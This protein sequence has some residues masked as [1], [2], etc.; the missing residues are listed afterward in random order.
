[1]SREP[2]FPMM[3]LEHRSPLYEILQ[4]KIKNYIIQNSLKPG[5]RLPPE[6]ELAQQLGVSRNSVREAVKALEMLD[7]VETRSGAG[8]FV[9]EFSFDALLDNFGYGIMFNLTE[10]AD[11]LEVRFHVE[12]GMI[13]RAVE[14]VTP[15]QIKRLR[16]IVEQM[17][18]AAK[19]D[20]YSAKND[21]LFH[22]TLWE[23]VDNRVVG[24]ILDVFWGILYQ[25]RKQTPVP[26][27]GDLMQTYERHL[28]IVEALEKQDVKALQR[29]MVFHYGGIR[30]RLEGIYK[31]GSIDKG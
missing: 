9:G 22:Q 19:N 12:Y 14:A 3:P 16:D 18:V 24:K 6:T 27:P 10:L 29:S 4:Q 31:H 21:R 23:N 13:P 5:D 20:N 1:M 25:A 26:D 15:E 8:L 28:K 2:N 17:Y 30:K 11:I 7:I